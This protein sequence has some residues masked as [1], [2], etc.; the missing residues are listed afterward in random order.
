MSE[1]TIQPFGAYLSDLLAD[2]NLPAASVSRMMGH[3]S[4]TTLQRILQDRANIESMEKFLAD[5]LAARLIALTPDEEEGLRSAL[6]ISRIGPDAIRAREEMWNLMRLT[7]EPDSPQPLYLHDTTSSESC[8][9]DDFFALLSSA[10]SIYMLAVNNVPTRFFEALKRLVRT[11]A[12]S[13]IQIEHYFFLT[14]D[15]ARTVRFVSSIVPALVIPSYSAY[16]V[17]LAHSDRPSVSSLTSSI[18]ACRIRF[19]SGETTEYQLGFSHPMPGQLLRLPGGAGLCEFWEGMLAPG[20]SIRLP[21]RYA[22]LTP[23][24]SPERCVRQFEAHMTLEHNHDIYMLRSALPP[25]VI[26]P[27]LPEKQLREDPDT[28]QSLTPGQI[29]TILD[30]H[31]ERF[32]NIFHKKRV[33]HLLMPLRSLRAFAETGSLPTSCCPMKSFTLEERRQ[34][35]TIC[36]DQARDNPYFNIYFLKTDPPDLPLHLSG[37]DP[38]GVLLHSADAAS[39]YSDALITLPEF[40]SLFSQF[41]RETLL[42]QHALS[43]SASVSVLG[44]LIDSLPA[45]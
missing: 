9:L 30:I 40:T 43:G 14:D 24:S 34:I 45:E 26:P 44:S 10:E 5:F 8:S 18:V 1:I 25:A 11:K 12:E 13:D 33:T 28:A 41:F 16:A 32:R 42:A 23:G 29:D 7:P 36:R 31:E 19:A 21:I 2:H 27:Q 15:V 20:K 37:Y 17:P 6:E 22:C 38:V 3:K 4:R 39:D 35:L